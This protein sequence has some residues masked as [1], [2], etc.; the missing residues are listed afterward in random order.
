M[1][2]VTSR[3]DFDGLRDPEGWLWEIM[4]LVARVF[5][6]VAAISRTSTTVPVMP[7]VEMD[8]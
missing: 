4:T 1:R 2:F 3:S 7:P 8:W 6:A 5:R